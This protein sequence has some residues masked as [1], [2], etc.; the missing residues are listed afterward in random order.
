MPRSVVLPNPIAVRHF[1]SVV[2]PL[3]EAKS[4]MLRSP[5]LRSFSLAITMSAAALFLGC[6]GGGPAGD[7]ATVSIQIVPPAGPVTEGVPLGL[8]ATVTAPAREEERPTVVWSMVTAGATG[9]S[10][11][12][13]FLPP[14]PGSFEIRASLPAFPGV[15]DAITLLVD[16]AAIQTISISPLVGIVPG[17]TIRPQVVG[18]DAVG[19][20]RLVRAELRVNDGFSLRSLGGGAFRADSVGT[21]TIAAIFLGLG[22][23]LPVSV[24]LGAPSTVGWLSPSPLPVGASTAI[25]VF[26]RDRRGNI[27]PPATASLSATSRVPSVVS[28]VALADSIVLTGVSS[29]S[30][31]VVVGVGGLTD[32]LLVSVVGAPDPVVFLE[33]T[34]QGEWVDWRRGT[35]VVVSATRMSGAT[36]VVTGQSA[37]TTI[38]GEPLSPIVVNGGSSVFLVPQR[39][40]FS[41]SIR[42][43]VGARSLVSLSYGGI[44]DTLDVPLRYRRPVSLGWSLGDSVQIPAGDTTAVSLTLLD[45]LGSTLTR[46]DV[47]GVVNPL[48]ASNPGSVSVIPGELLVGL[49]PP[50]STVTATYT[51]GGSSL[52]RSAFVAVT[53]PLPTTTIGTGYVRLVTS[54]PPTASQRSALEAAVLRIERVMAPSPLSPVSI[55]VPAG[56]C[57]PG[58]PAL[59]GPL[60]GLTVVF[61]LEAIDGVGSVLGGAG[62]CVLR[63]EPSGR[64]LVGF[65]FFDVAD[66]DNLISNNRFVDVVT[67]EILH[68]LGVG[69]MWPFLNLATGM[70]GSDP[71]Y[72]GALGFAGYQSLGGTQPS[73]AVENIGGAGTAGSHWRDGFFGN[74]LMTGFLGSGSNPMSA[75]TVESLRDLG[76]TVTSANA[77]P[78]LLPPGALVAGQ[79]VVRDSGGLDIHRAERVYHPWLRVSPGG[80]LSTFGPKPDWPYK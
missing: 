53:G 55:D 37:I 79:G 67:H 58:T 33:A 19:R 41:G 18:R 10:R 21:S 9:L 22:S 24:T 7:S 57:A 15:S 64:P 74:E 80:T 68:A 2:N 35:E 45:S 49:S 51:E 77:E 26:S 50:G 62:P 52:V 31:W 5:L 71:R 66:V 3:R 38:S 36:A 28:A 34:L 69:T 27:L 11:D 25:S 46:G 59:S 43:D 39:P 63:A 6:G 20:D 65:M 17:D 40:P 70:G 30:S 23:L 78:Y 12:G 44:T 61:T 14:R 47:F 13:M 4:L 48:L 60:G 29:G 73:V 1:Q 76:Y 16:S 54:T 32:S 56:A 75:L 72:I 42:F 8:R